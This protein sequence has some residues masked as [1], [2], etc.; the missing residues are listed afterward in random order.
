MNVMYISPV[1]VC[2]CVFVP[3]GR[4]GCLRTVATRSQSA[5]CSG[6]TFGTPAILLSASGTVCLGEAEGEDNIGW[7]NNKNNN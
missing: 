3:P 2:L 4:T 1:F 7:I 6:S 5:A